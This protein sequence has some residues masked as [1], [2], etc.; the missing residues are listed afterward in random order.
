MSFYP[1][2][3]WTGMSSL[4]RRKQR[5]VIVKVSRLNAA[6]S[7]RE[8]SLTLV[9]RRDWGGRGLLGCHILPL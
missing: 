8:Q 2:S 4:T 1:W 7:Q 5:A 6:P 3:G 9:P